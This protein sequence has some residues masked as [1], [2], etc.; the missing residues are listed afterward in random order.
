MWIEQASISPLLLVQTLEVNHDSAWAIIS[1]LFLHLDVNLFR[2]HVSFADALK[3]KNYFLC[4]RWPSLHA[5]GPSESSH[6]AYGVH[7]HTRGV[8]AFGEWG[9]GW[10]TWLRNTALVKPINAH[11]AS[12]TTKLIG[13][14]E[15]LLSAVGTRSLATAALWQLMPYRLQFWCSS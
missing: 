15:T 7:V 1:D 2:H 4:C 6:P 9:I 3:V 11:N 5:E 8:G 12:Q 14:E 10:V 13:I